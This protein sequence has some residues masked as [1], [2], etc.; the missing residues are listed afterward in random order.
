MAKST[1]LPALSDQQLEI[2]SC[3]WEL[4]E[5]TVTDVWQE[6]SKRKK[7][8]R[9]TVLTVMDRLAKRG[10]L[11]KK[12]LQNTHLYSATMQRDQ[13]LG[14][15]VKN[16]VESAFSDSPDRLM[17]ALIDSRGITAA[18]ADRIKAMIDASR[19]RKKS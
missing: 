10:W 9:T 2:M 15:M 11:L 14:G 3:I 4:S 16:L 1:S 19:K 12:R 18:E 6:I 13:V 5:A 17:M 8:A 7:L